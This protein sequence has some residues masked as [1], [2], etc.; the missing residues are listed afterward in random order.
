MAAE[1]IFDRIKSIQDSYLSDFLPR[2]IPGG[3]WEG[4]RYVAGGIEGGKGHSFSF[5]LKKGVGADYA[6]DGRG[7]DIIDLAAEVW[8]TSK[9]EAATRL[10]K[11]WG[12]NTPNLALVK[13]V[14]K[15]KPEYIP[16]HPVPEGEPLSIGAW[17]TE[18]KGNIISKWPYHNAKGQILGYIVRFS[19]PS[20]KAVPFQWCGKYGWQSVGFADPRPLY[21][22]HNLA[23]KGTILVAEGE[24]AAV[25]ASQ[26]F[27]TLIATTWSGGTNAVKKTDWTPLQERN[28]II[29]RD[30][31]FTKTDKSGNILPFHEQP[32]KKA[33]IEICEILT[34]LDCSVRIFKD[35]AF[36]GK[37]DGWDAADFAAESSNTG[38]KALDWL[39]D[40]LIEYQ[41]GGADAAPS[42]DSNKSARID[43]PLNNYYR[44]LGQVKND[45]A[46]YNFRSGQIIFRSCEKITKKF[47]LS[48]SNGNAKY[49]IDL[50]GFTNEKEERRIDWDTAAGG[51]M[52]EC[53]YIGQFDIDRIRGTG[54]W[55]DG[56]HIV[57]NSGEFLYIESTKYEITDFESYF[58]YVK[59]PPIIRRMDTGL[60]ETELDQLLELCNMFAWEYPVSGNLLAGWL[61]VA[62]I[63]GALPWRPHIYITGM[64]G[65][66]K[67]TIHD[68]L[69]ARVLGDCSIV[70]LGDSTKAGLSQSV[71]AD[72]LPIIFDEIEN[73]SKF[74]EQR[75]DMVLRMARYSS[76][77]QK[78][79]T[80]KGTG[81][82]SGAKGYVMRS[83]FCFSSISPS[84]KHYA[85]YSRITLLPLIVEHSK[86]KEQ[87]VEHYKSIMKN[88]KNLMG[89]ETTSYNFSEKFVTHANR[90]ALSIIASYRTLKEV[91][92]ITIPNFNARIADQI[93]ML[94]AGYWAYKSDQPITNIEAT[95][96]L[97]SYNWENLIPNKKQ[98][99][100]MMLISKLRQYKIFLT[101]ES[102]Q[103]K[104]NRTMADLIE[105]VSYDG[106]T[107][108]KDKHFFD[109]KY[110]A[111]LLQDIGI[112]IESNFVCVANTSQTLNHI[113]QG[114]QWA[115]NW[116]H[117]L[118]AIPG[119]FPGETKYF[120]RAIGA[121]RCTLV[122][123]DVFISVEEL[124][125]GRL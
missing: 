89:A 3:H 1:S 49:W 62:P 125:D 5:S 51:L 30:H 18:N 27:P 76:S 97:S 41:R 102:S 110:A 13:P 70:T 113:L 101:N 64:A 121:Q 39:K 119:A 124:D 82:Q 94:M 23:A 78:G 12:S 48:L 22:L 44:L 116:H 122:P 112:R 71:E 9:I 59:S 72:A 16:V 4:D 14:A 8:G 90:N 107:E 96:L 19:D 34:D 15:K 103:K 11:E 63:C 111:S 69:L 21:N 26:L 65:T 67:S 77:S 24:K 86:A 106:V 42:Q 33:E 115:N 108:H 84:V 17:W 73:D 85:D 105:Y 38:Q 91:A 37:S 99:N 7:K 104:Y 95:N 74:D 40:N 55:I 81:D 114:T 46:F 35:N 56:S 10:E 28:I 32:G 75:N 80:L 60:D 29:W 58:L 88:I 123:L 31:D 57:F 53:H 47:L 50:Y 109:E 100:Q 92:Q 66:G 43:K 117:S 6:L 79:K 68:N 45:Y 61:M 83:C 25:A 120:G 118:K 98:E 54:C 2:L 87:Q 36:E 52:A 20:A 93:G